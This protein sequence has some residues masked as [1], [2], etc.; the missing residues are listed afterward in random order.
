MAKAPKKKNNLPPLT[1]TTCQLLPFMLEWWLICRASANNHRYFEFITAMS[2]PCAEDVITQGPSRSSV[3]SILF[4]VK[5]SL[6]ARGWVLISNQFRSE[7]SMVIYSLHFDRLWGSA[8]I[9]SHCKRSFSD[10]GWEL[11]LFNGCTHIYKIVWQHAQLSKQI[12]FPP[13]SF[14]LPNYGV[15]SSLQ[16]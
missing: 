16:Y 12:K 6:E 7:H 5:L 14:D 4:F 13:G 11:C 2:M 3:F 9:A 8:L 10:Q 15:T 1:A